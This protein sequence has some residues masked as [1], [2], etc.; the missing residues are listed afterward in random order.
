M[1]TTAKGDLPEMFPSQNHG[2]E[3]GW[4]SWWWHGLS[5]IPAGVALEDG[6][7]WA[8]GMMLCAEKRSEDD[9]G[10]DKAVGSANQR[11]VPS[12]C[13]WSPGLELGES[14]QQSDLAVGWAD[15]HEE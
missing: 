13:P 6:A 3:M 9:N 14:F 5:M 1:P 12:P 4:G 10:P 7:G 8:D 11:Y 15:T 2:L